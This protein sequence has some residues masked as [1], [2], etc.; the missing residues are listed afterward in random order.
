MEQVIP[1]L[2]SMVRGQVSQARM[3]VVAQDGCN[4]ILVDVVV[5]SP[6]AGG[7]R[8]TAMC[9]RRDGYSARRAATAKKAKYDSPDL[10]SF[11]LE[12]GG[13]LGMDARSF[14]KKLASAAEE[15]PLEVAYL[16]RAI[17]ATLQDGI[18]KQLCQ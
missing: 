15:P 16:Y 9:A 10:L 2:A 17:S 14:I 18:A 1:Q 12:T 6:Y 3:D 13:R 8:F 7:E 5:S 11:A 4:R